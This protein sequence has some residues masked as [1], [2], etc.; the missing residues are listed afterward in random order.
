MPWY[1]ISRFV[2][3]GNIYF[4]CNWGLPANM[5][6]DQFEFVDKAD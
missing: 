5:N 4:L 2:S 3:F 1:S 6:S